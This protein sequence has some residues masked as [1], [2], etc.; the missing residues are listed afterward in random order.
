[1]IYGRDPIDE[2]GRDNKDLLYGLSPTRIQTGR[3]FTERNEGA[4]R[5]I[6]QYNEAIGINAIIGGHRTAVHL[7]DVREQL[8]SKGEWGLP[9]D[10]NLNTPANSDA[11][12]DWIDYL[13]RHAAHIGLEDLGEK[14]GFFTKARIEQKDR[15]KKNRGTSQANASKDDQLTPTDTRRFLSAT[16]TRETAEAAYEDMSETKQRALDDWVTQA[17]F[18]RTSKLG[19]DFTVKVLAGTILFNTVADPNYQ[20]GDPNWQA[21]GVK[22]MSERGKVR[23]NR[24]ITVSEYRHCRS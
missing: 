3:R 13:R 8:A 14:G 4:L 22:T 1:M 11:I 12:L 15:F 5:S 7:Y 18:R 24:P 23:K 16:H 19:Q 21:H 17:F 10:A 20:G 9:M 2:I 6:D